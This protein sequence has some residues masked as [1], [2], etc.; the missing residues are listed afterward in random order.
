MVT[1]ASIGSQELD[2][3]SVC[4]VPSSGKNQLLLLVRESP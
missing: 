4:P 1:R 2:V 3:D